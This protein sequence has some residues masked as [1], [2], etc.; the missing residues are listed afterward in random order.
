MFIKFPIS[1]SVCDPEERERAD[2]LNIPAQSEQDIRSVYVDPDRIES[3]YASHIS[4]KGEKVDAINLQMH[5]GDLFTV[6]SEMD[7]F[8]T[9]IQKPVS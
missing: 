7:S 3:F 6:L 5:S 9:R 4:H 1:V 2:L 8:I